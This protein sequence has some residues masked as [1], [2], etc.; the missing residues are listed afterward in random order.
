ML[1]PTDAPT[2]AA[3]AT[4]QV[5]RARPAFPLSLGSHRTVLPP[6]TASLV[7]LGL[8]ERD[9]ATIQ[10]LAGTHEPTH[11]SIRAETRGKSHPFLPTDHVDR[12]YV[13]HAFSHGDSFRIIHAAVPCAHALRPSVQP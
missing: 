13:D 7:C 12:P 2:G 8:P 1:P 11:R 6:T 5:A 4:V 3:Y 9:A 10:Y